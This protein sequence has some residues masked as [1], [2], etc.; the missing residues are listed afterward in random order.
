[1]YHPAVVE[2]W[3]VAAGYRVHVERYGTAGI[4]YWGRQP[5]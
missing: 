2:G 3:L 5:A 1:V 4:A